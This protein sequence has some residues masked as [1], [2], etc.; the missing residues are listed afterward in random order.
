MIGAALG[1][2]QMSRSFSQ[3]PFNSFQFLLSSR[4]LFA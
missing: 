1:E 2:L 4:A 3:V